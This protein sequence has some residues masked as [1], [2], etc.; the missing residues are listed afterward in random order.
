MLPRGTFGGTISIFAPEIELMAQSK[1]LAAG[2]L[3]GGTI[4]VE[5]VDSL[6]FEGFADARSTVEAAGG[7]I[8]F[9]TEDLSLGGVALVGPGGT[10]IYDPN[11]LDVDATEAASIVSSLNGG[12]TVIVE[13][14][15][16]IN[17]NSAIDSSTQGSTATL[18]F[19]DE[20]SNDTLT[21]NLGADISV[22]DNQDITFDGDIVLAGT[23][24]INGPA[25]SFQDTVAAGAFDLTLITDSLS[26]SDTVSGTGNLTIENRTA[27]TTIGIGSGAGTLSISSAMIGQLQDGFASITIGSS[28]AGTITLSPVTFADPVTLIGNGT[29]IGADQTSTYTI[30][31]AGEGEVTGFG[32]TVSFEGITQ[33]TA[34]NAA[35]TFD[36]Q[37]GGSMGTLDLTAGGDDE[38]DFSNRASATLDL[39][40]STASG[41]TSITAFSNIVKVTGNAT[42]TSLVLTDAA[43]D[44]VV[45]TGVDD[46]GNGTIDFEDITNLDGGGGTNSLTFAD[47]VNTVTVDGLDQGSLTGGLNWDNFTDL[48][49]GS[50]ADTFA[51]SGTTADLTSISGGGGTDI[52]DYVSNTTF[53][54]VEVDL[55]GGTATD[56][57]G[58]S[59]VSITS[60]EQLDGSGTTTTLKLGTGD[61]EVT[62]TGANAGGLTGFTFSGVTD[63]DGGTGGNQLTFADAAN[64]VT[65]DGLDQGSLTG[66]L[67]WDNFTDLVGGSM[68]DTFAFSGTTAD[69]TSIN[70]GG[71]TDIIDYVSNATFAV[72]EVDL[73][74]GTS[75]D[76]D[77]VSGVNIS[78]IEQLDGSGTTTT[79]KLGTGDDEVTLTGANAGGLTG[80]TFSG[81]TDLDGGTGGN[82]LTFADAANTVTVD[83]AD[84]GT[85]TGGLNWDNFTDLV[86]G[87]MAD[88]FAFSGTTADLTSIDGGGGTDELDY[89]TNATFAAVEVD[90]GPATQTATDADGVSGLN[91]AS[92]EVL[93][94]DGS[95][96]TLSIPDT[97]VTVTIDGDGQG[98]FTGFSFTGV[99]DLV[100]GSMADTFAFSG[101]TADLTS[102][103]GGG[104]TDIIDYVSNT[105]FTTVEVDLESGT[106]TDADGVSGV[107]ISSIEQLDGSGTTTTLKLGTGDDEVTLTGA[108]AGGL[109]GFTFSGVTDLDGGTGGNQLTFADAANT[110]TVDGLDQGSLTGGLNWDN[111]TDLVGGSM[112]DTFA[113]SG[114][115]A[116]LTSINGGGG[117]DIIDYVSNATFAVVEVDLENGTST[118][119]DGVSGVNI[120]SIEQLDGSGTTTTLKL[121][122]GD[123]EVTLTGANA[124]GLT[125]FTFSGV[126][127]L[128]GGTGGNQLTFADAANTVTVDGADQGTLTG[129]LNWDNFTDLVG[130]SMA[131]TFAFSGTTADLTS[132][133]GGGGTDELDYGTNAT[134]TTVEVDLGPAT[135]TA[136]DA[137]GVS[138]LNIAS[139][140][141]LTGDGADTTLSIPDTGVTVTIDGDGQGSFTG[142]SFT[143]VTDLVGGSMADTFAFSGT[144]ADLTSISGGGGTDII[145]YVSNTS[146]TTVEV[147][148]ESGTATDADG[149]SGVNISSIEQLDGSGTTTTLKLGTGDDEVTL[150][151]ANA[152]GLTGFTFSGVTDLDGGTGGNQLTFADAANTVTVDGLD[153]GS[154]TGGLNWD[155]F[156][157]LVGGSMADTFA[158]SGTTADLTSINGGGG[159]DIIDYVSNATFAVVEVDLENGTSTDTDGVSGVNI[160]SIE[161]LDGSGTTTTLKLGTGDDEVTLTGANAGG[162]TG[163]TFSGV[164]DLDGGTGGNQLTFA[165]AANTVT[166]DG[167]DQGTLTGGLNWDNFTDL[168]GGSMA[169]TFAFSGTTADLTSIDGG[170][171]TDELDYGTNATFTT[172]EVDLGPA[173]QTATDADG[174]SGLN[175]ASIEVLTG[176]GA[177]TTLSI[178]DTGVTVTIDGDGQGS[179]T[180]FS[181]TGVT[182]L[183]GGSMADTFAFSG[184]T[185]DLTSI[186]GGGGNDELDYAT[187]GTFAAVEVDLGPATQTATD[188]DGVSGLNIASIEVL[189]GDGTDTTL[190]IPDTGVTVTV[191]GDGQ[192]SFT[193][194]SFTG[195]TDLVGGSM[196]DTF[197]FDGNTG[198]LTSISGGGGNDELDYATSGT[199]AAVEVD[200][201]NGTATDADG[202]AGVNIA[203]VEVLTG[204][205]ANTTLT[206]DTGDDEVTLTG[207]NAGGLTGFTFS[208]VTGLDG[209]T[210]G[211]QLTFADAAN[212]ITVDGAD[213]GTLTGG[214]NWDNFTDLVGG[215][216]ADTFAFSGT[217]AD[218]TSISG[219]GGTDILD[220]V[221]NATFAVVEVDLEN[222]TAT[223]V[224][225]V[226]GV[227]ISSIEQLDGSGTTTT[228]KL[229]TGD[230]EVTLTGG[231][232]GNFT[233]FS[234]SGVTDLDGGTGGNELTFAAGGVGV[235]ID[236]ADQGS[237]TGGLNWDNFTDLIGGSGDDSFTFSG[238]MGNL[239]SISG[240]SAGSD[241]LDYGTSGT[242]AA[243]EVDLENGTATDAGGVAGVNITSVEVLTGDGADTTLKLDTGDDEVTLTG[244]NAGSFTGFSFSG[245]TDLDGG[246]GGNQLTFADAV[247]TV[248]VDGLDQGSLT[249]GLNWDNFTDLVGGSLADT[250]A[251]SG[252]TADLTS[253]SG[254]GG[255]DILDYVTNATFAVVEVDLESGT[256]TDVDGVSGVNIS[257]IEQLDGSGT[258]TTLKLDTGDD[259]VTL[260]GANAGGLTGFTFSGVTDLD[261]GTGGN[262]LTFADAVNTITIDGADQGTLTGGLNWDNFTDLVGGSMADTFAFSGTAADLTSIDGGGGSDELD[263]G[264]NA[265]FA[266]V[267]VDLGPATQTATDVDGTTGV[268]ISSIEALM[269]NSSDTTLSIPDTGVTVTI[270]GDGQGSFTGFSFTGVTDLVGGSLADTFRFDGNTGN[271]T[272]ISGGGGNDELDYGT[273]GT[274]AAVEVDLGPAT[275]TATDADGVSGLNIASIEV[276]TG[277]GVDTT[278]SIPDTGVTVT[279]DGDRQ[280]SF[281][282]FSFTG[283]TDLVGGS[284]ADTFAFSGTTADLTSISGGGGTDILDYVTNATFAVVEVDLESG[285]A[286]DVDGVSG[287]NI[288]SIEQLDGSGTTTTLKLD[289][290]DDEVTLTGANAGGLTGFTFSGVT[291]LDGGTGGNELTFADAVNTITIDGADQ[292]TLTGGL[293]WDN[294]TDLVG[295]SM[296]DTFAFSGTTADLTSIDGGGG[297][298]I[299]DYLSNATFAVVEVDLENGTATDADG[300]AGVNIS[301]I[302][303]LDGSGTTTTLKLTT[304]NDSVNL[305]GAN[306]GNLTGFQLLGCN[307]TGYCCWYR[308]PHGSECEHDLDSQWTQQWHGAFHCLHWSRKPHRRNS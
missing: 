34:G 222:G 89:G 211:N 58:V 83:G 8:D 16:T 223:D 304:G 143:G 229:D 66:G 98:S 44:A 2:D 294:F 271:L 52:I 272:S 117:T 280:G 35:D 228:L 218:L 145:D 133:D 82:Q 140:E 107:N 36:I 268:E 239:T 141:V 131:D 78:S 13:A 289:T 128:D 205:G 154:L 169:D 130:G 37:T 65:V 132:I 193:G 139:I 182:D 129:G 264:T 69:L 9:A 29:L 152:G 51:F 94:G 301:S 299:L 226:A 192:G 231:N 185:A 42:N 4:L 79:L 238:N 61:D 176:D 5:G 203:S 165:D 103:S 177:D 97:G 195:V 114:T 163:F 23:A 22:G 56:A 283:V 215:S 88:T 86:G 189:T 181:F 267:E 124:G 21:I 10:V 303:Q 85:L 7:F 84:Q 138:G 15:N 170:G 41:I 212:T 19:Q 206:L 43:D 25:L 241:T 292:G 191:D 111:F 142:F 210:G 284:L 14:R 187:S 273:S 257:S 3:K 147:D 201:E 253:I 11:T 173:T 77:G 186:S 126:T 260:T 307:I 302:E 159:T 109:T 198:N 75:T 269:G 261:G 112:A 276:L 119:T 240:G 6:V 104:G 71:G 225:G 216:M 160:S 39:E 127:D 196:A 275:R 291:D 188:A 93:T 270:D 247:N 233:G 62:L 263:Y 259:E 214:L 171:G 116:D 208:G 38:I 122:T 199:F 197:R 290:G 184:T 266:V 297:T 285:T 55:G 18:L 33:I 183:V 106:A 237:L 17:V 74:N 224:D 256:A 148:L 149:V 180:G 245:V 87:S 243:V 158:F 254:G 232:A 12:G 31:G 99:T 204:D 246:T 151:G 174:V 298:D 164:T 262:E 221:S 255:T 161:Q 178:P 125:G 235:V 120:S 1:L 95:D 202:V 150:T 293:N 278:L 248:T 286:T 213:Q 92:I 121:G 296:A 258:T 135:Q 155:N 236:G 156:T 30:D 54:T 146:F 32:A 76:T 250:F 265:T 175:I 153:Q 190:S 277:D 101:T 251:F 220:Y 136:T 73:E 295:G 60:I 46:G 70:G 217:T 306:A 28:D 90:L 48:V 47:A 24:N 26:F 20:N 137:D 230:D 80:F 59:G 279:I 27:N 274:F 123:D 91:I 110:V 40:N 179:F 168:V 207:G 144:T 68:A 113:F 282:G 157:D 305:T 281:T 249:G 194:F 219:G 162:L 244:G 287:V 81:V 96:T 166:V 63:L 234:F 200:L 102:I 172:V 108:N 242:F 67:N 115:T 288:S 49:G 134:F 118:D 105:S 57:D 252:T 100:G 64:T 45:L 227:N 167:A 209:G 53:T 50:M 308:H 300:V 72:V